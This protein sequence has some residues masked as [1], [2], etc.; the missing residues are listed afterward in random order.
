MLNS[1]AGAAIAACG[2]AMLLLVGL[3]A[4]EDQPTALVADRA[5]LRDLVRRGNDAQDMLDHSVIAY[6]K[7]KYV[8]TSL[9]RDVQLGCAQQPVATTIISSPCAP[10]GEGE[11]ET[12]SPETTTTTTSTAGF[13]DPWSLRQARLEATAKEVRHVDVE[14][15]LQR[16]LE[17]QM[18]KIHLLKLALKSKIKTLQKSVHQAPKD[19]DDDPLWKGV[20]LHLTQA[21][22]TPPTDEQ[23]QASPGHVQVTAM[24]LSD[25][26]AE[27]KELKKL[28][29]LRGSSRRF[30]G[31]EDDGKEI[32][33]T[34]Q[35]EISTLTPPSSSLFWEWEP[36]LHY[37]DL[38]P[39][40]KP[41]KTRTRVVERRSSK[42]APT[43]GRRPQPIARKR[44][45]QPTVTH[46]VKSN[47]C[48]FCRDAE[49]YLKDSA[50]PD[51]RGSKDADPSSEL[52]FFSSD[53]KD[54]QE[55]ADF[56]KSFPNTKDLRV[57]DWL[58]AEADEE[59]PYDGTKDSMSATGAI[60]SI[61]SG[62][63]DF[64]KA[65]GYYTH[66]GGW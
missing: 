15:H 28:D 20:D 26:K 33:R 58:G 3:R 50:R 4:G 46:R 25:P 7:G 47:A 44:K 52:P 21:D 40:G 63:F 49:K 16:D 64:P 59:S 55:G 66:Y 51:S 12:Y 2:V 22:L 43:R 53:W 23:R 34:E 38:G 29:Y 60:S 48:F 13:L 45:E 31:R 65:S 19:D 41:V 24:I 36:S 8:D 54:A 35:E 14:T 11:V 57:L 39:D 37:H 9:W 6:P 17:R 27:L 5:S 32:D 30:K 10:T 56:V 18:N 62:Y 42:P 61:P 1:R